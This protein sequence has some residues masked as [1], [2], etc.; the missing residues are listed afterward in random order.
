MWPDVHSRCKLYTTRVRGSA[1]TRLRL[2]LKSYKLPQCIKTSTGFGGVQSP[3]NDTMIHSSLE[4]RPAYLHLAKI[5]VKKQYR[6]STIDTRHIYFDIH[7]R[8]IFLSCCGFSST[9]ALKFPKDIIAKTK[10][11]GD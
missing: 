3:R 2:E 5:P 10:H 11:F 8:Y 9:E 7:D 1:Y 4:F 6:R